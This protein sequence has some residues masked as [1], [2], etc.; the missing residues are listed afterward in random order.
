MFSAAIIRGKPGWSLGLRERLQPG[1]Q[2]ILFAPQEDVLWARGLGFELRDT[3]LVLSPR[4]AS[5]VYLLRAPLSG[6]I[7]DSM[8]TRGS[9]GINIAASR[10]RWKNEADSRSALPGSMPGASDSIGTFQTR[11]RSG[12]R[13]E[14]FQDKD[15]R[16]PTNVV[17]VHGACQ[18]VGTKRVRSSSPSPSIGKQTD[19]FAS[20]YADEDGFEAVDAWDC[21]PGCPVAQLDSQSGALKSGDVRPYERANRGGYA[22]PTQAVS[23]F[24]RSGDAGGAS[25][26]YPQ[27]ANH[28]ELLDW[29]RTLVACPGGQLLEVL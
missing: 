7:T 14:D 8:V 25:R 29:L 11:D 18:S 2:V 17:L 22:G 21:E 10:I 24:D 26:F 4:V 5:Y 20:G 16:W 1:A 19:S 15:G 9:G 27:F 28:G 6:S 13:P 12:E 23:G 3:L